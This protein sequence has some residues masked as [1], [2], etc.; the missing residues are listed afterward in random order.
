MPLQQ[1]RQVLFVQGAGPDAHDGWDD[2]LADS[3]QR[4]LGDD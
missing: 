4:A 2:K 1:R 3:L